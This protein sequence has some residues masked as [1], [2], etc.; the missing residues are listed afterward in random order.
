MQTVITYRPVAVIDIGTSS[1]RMAIAEIGSDSS[2]RILDRLTQAV[3]LGKDTFTRGSIRHETIEDCVQVLLG[4][5]QV[6][7]EYE[8]TTPEQLHVIATSAV[9]EASNQLA[10]LDRIYIAT[11]LQVAAM[12]EAEINRITYLGIRRELTQMSTD[13]TIVVCEVGGGSTELLAV[14]NN[15]IDFAHTYKL[16][17]LRLRKTLDSYGAPITQSRHLMEAEIKRTTGLLHEHVNSEHPLRLVALGGDIRFAANQINGSWDSTT[18]AT[19]D[20]ET[21][22]TLTNDILAM[23]LDTIAQ[24][25]SLDITFQEAETLGPALLAYVEISKQL[26]IQQIQVSGANLRDGLLQ[27][28]ALEEAWSREFQNQ[29]IGSVLDLGRHFDFDEAHAIHVASLASDLFDQLQP[30]HNLDPRYGTFLRVAAYLHEI[31]MFINNRGYHKHTMYLIN[32]SELFGLGKTN[33]LLIA[34]IARY[35]RRASPQPKH[36]GFSTLNRDNRVAVSKLAAILRVAVALDA[37]RNQA[38][39]QIHCKS[40][41]KQLIVSTL[42]ATDLSLEQLTL[43]QN[44]S[45]FEEVFGLR[46][47][48]RSHATKLP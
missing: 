40:D 6:L 4:Y 27:E 25:Y 17:S 45:L 22:E 44:G 5:K 19:I 12:D 34:L 26:Q 48:L 18:G 37:S 9:R 39:H 24:Q 32:N 11:E 8:I 15:Q 10:F 31:G 16:G 46:I 2:I 23:P 43:K 3:N 13:A 7:L 41:D 29:I 21:L 42:D 36:D 30:Q 47:L 33:L 35:H 14:R 28:M 1:I 38:I 20:R